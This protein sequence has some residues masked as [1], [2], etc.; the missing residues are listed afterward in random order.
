LHD[1]KLGQAGK[2][3]K[4]FASTKAASLRIKGHVAGLDFAKRAKALFFY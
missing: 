3:E 4:I 1:S 2:R